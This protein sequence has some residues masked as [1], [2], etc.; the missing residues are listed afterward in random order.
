MR[1]DLDALVHSSLLEAVRAL[2]APTSDLEIDL[3]EE[4]RNKRL[5]LSDTVQAQARRY[6]DAVKRGTRLPFTEA[7]ALARL[8]RRRPDA[9]A[10]FRRAGHHLA[11]LAIARVG[12]VART[13]AR[14]APAAL[15]RPVAL[16]QADRI[17]RR[18]LEGRVRREGGAVLLEVTHPVTLD[19]SPNA[20]GCAF[21][22]AAFRAMLEGLGQ[23]VGV[24]DRVACR[25]RGDRLC[26]WR[27]EWKR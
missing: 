17:A 9:E 6:A 5:G 24:I 16:R 27:T 11:E 7:V 19:A 20:T 22:D 23:D 18:Y 8:I 13:T 12:A 14:S 2:D 3:F 10:V 25:T 26:A 21:Y 15:A 1:G 4:L